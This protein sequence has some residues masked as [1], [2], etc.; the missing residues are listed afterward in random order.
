MTPAILS[1]GVDF[2]GWNMKIPL[3]F[4]DA[5]LLLDDWRGYV[6]LFCFLALLV[7]LGFEINILRELYK[8]LNDG[9]R[10]NKQKDNG[11]KNNGP[12]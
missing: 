9:K 11:K 5:Y 4:T 8:I 12:R 1:V 6:Y 3:P 2:D 10:S 7:C